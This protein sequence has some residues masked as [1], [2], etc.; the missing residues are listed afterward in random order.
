M[1]EPAARAVERWSVELADVL[2]EMS[3]RVGRLAEL[4][5]DDWPDPRGRDVAER[6]VLVGRELGR[7]AV[8]AAE[9]GHAYARAAEDS[10]ADGTTDGTTGSGDTGTARL[11][12]PTSG[13]PGIRLGD[14]RGTRADEERGMRIA[15]LPAARSPEGG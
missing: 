2:T 7:E 4:I 9:L 1:S 10:A 12:H 14:P 6:S 3:R 13:G 15:E 8:V 5:A 11:P